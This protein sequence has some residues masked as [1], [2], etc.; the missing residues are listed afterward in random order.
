MTDLGLLY[1]CGASCP[2]RQAIDRYLP[3]PPVG[4]KYLREVHYNQQRSIN[5]VM[6]RVIAYMLKHL[7]YL[8]ICEVERLADGIQ[9]YLHG[10]E[11]G[12][13]PRMSRIDPLK[14]AQFEGPSDKISEEILQV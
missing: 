8:R 4:C 2:T 1:L 13:H 11:G 3:K 6:P 9:Y 5:P 10:P 7:K 14:L 12:Y